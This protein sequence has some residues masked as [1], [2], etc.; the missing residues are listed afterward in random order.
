MIPLLSGRLIRPRTFSLIGIGTHLR[1]VGEEWRMVF[2]GPETKSGRPLERTVPERI[3]PFL[4]RYLREVRPLFL[5]ANR[6]EGLWAGTKAGPLKGKE[7]YRIFAARTRSAF[8]QPIGPHLFRHCAATTIAIL[9]P[10][11]IGVARD[12]LEHTSIATT[13]AYYN[14]AR[15]IEASSLYAGVLIGLTPRPL[16]RSKGSYNGFPEI[17]GHESLLSQAAVAGNS[18]SE[19]DPLCETAGAQPTAQ[20]ERIKA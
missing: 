18:Y 16:R 8:G 5:G 7:I 11:R 14:K 20:S 15:S 13:H 10:G 12:L 6:H 3:V 4:E 1:R 17:S 9:E 19:V 2:E